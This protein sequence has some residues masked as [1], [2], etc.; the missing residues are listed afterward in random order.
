[1]RRA[2]TAVFL[3]AVLCATATSPVAV[4]QMYRWVDENGVVNYGDRPPPVRA[5]GARTVSESAGSLSVV[6]GISKDEM[7]RL[8][9]RDEQQRI[10]QLERENEELRARERARAAQPPAVVVQ[11]VYVPA[12]GYPSGARPP[13]RPPGARPEP[14]VDR[15]KPPPRPQPKADAPLFT[16]GK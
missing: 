1:M 14:P 9:E 11:E 4:A 10:Q 6:P 5:K 13:H 8:R 2:S 12:Y 7:Q 15:P 3:G 16:S